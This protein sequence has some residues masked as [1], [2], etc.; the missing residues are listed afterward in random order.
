MF[1]FILVDSS[2]G[3]W[4]PACSFLFYI[5]L[6]SA[7]CAA[8]FKLQ[9]QTDKQQPN[10]DCLAIFCNCIRLN[11]HNKSVRVHIY[12]HGVYIYSHSPVISRTNKTLGIQLLLNVE[13]NRSRIT[14]KGE[15]MLNIC[16]FK[17]CTM[18]LLPIQ[19]NKHL[20]CLKIFQIIFLVFA[21][22][23]SEILTLCFY[24][25]KQDKVCFL[26]L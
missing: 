7:I 6:P 9:H 1:Q 10:K 23:D 19:R 20:I 21:C 17:C 4:V 8:D 13:K 18:T 5:C 2:S 11:L 15:G 22:R 25:F 12:A 16:A 14:R 26:Y 24:F 3:S